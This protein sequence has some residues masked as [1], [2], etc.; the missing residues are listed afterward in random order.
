MLGGESLGFGQSIAR[1]H[2]NLNLGPVAPPVEHQ[3][4]NGVGRAPVQCG[5]D[6]AAAAG[7]IRAGCQ[8]RQIQD[9]VVGD[10]QFGGNSA[11][12]QAKGCCPHI[13][14]R[15]FQV[16]RVKGHLAHL[17]PAATGAVQQTD[18]GVSEV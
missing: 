14:Q 15:L 12:R 2:R 1:N 5:A 13:T 18:G 11:R 17:M 6:L 8:N 16:G 7:G 10:D 4:I 9:L 3:I